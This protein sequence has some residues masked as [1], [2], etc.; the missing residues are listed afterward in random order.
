METN[1]DTDTE[2]DTETDR[3]LRVRDVL[4]LVPVG[5]STW[6]A[7]VASGRFPQPV[8]LG[9]RCSCWRMSDIRRLI[10]EGVGGRD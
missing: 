4:R 6:H 10:S 5:V 9:K 2:I 8:R 3:L 7:G 1:T